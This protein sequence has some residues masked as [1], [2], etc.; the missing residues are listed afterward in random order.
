MLTEKLGVPCTP[1]HNQNIDATGR[2]RVESG[3]LQAFCVQRSGCSDQTIEKEER[4]DHGSRSCAARQ[5]Q[6]GSV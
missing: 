1:A 5:D 4:Q 6:E 3:L 2:Q